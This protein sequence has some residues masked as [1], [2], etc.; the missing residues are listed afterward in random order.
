MI[1]ELQQRPSAG[2]GGRAVPGPVSPE[3]LLFV[4]QPENNDTEPWDWELVSH[5]LRTYQVHVLLL[6]V[7]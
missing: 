2:G 4:P 7:Y 6:L 3:L 1:G 5:I